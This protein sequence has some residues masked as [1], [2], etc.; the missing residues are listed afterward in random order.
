MKFTLYDIDKTEA[1]WDPE[2]N[3]PHLTDD[4]L[5]QI[6]ASL[7]TY[8]DDP[9]DVAFESCRYVRAEYEAYANEERESAES[10]QRMEE[11]QADGLRNMVEELR[12]QNAQLETDLEAMYRAF[13][14]ATTGKHTQ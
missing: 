11:R 10:R 8:S 6:V 5:T 13:R 14:Y 2:E 7:K 3:P 1:W 4:Y 9:A 12:R